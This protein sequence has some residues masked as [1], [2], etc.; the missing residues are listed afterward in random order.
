MS[1][2]SVAETSRVEQI[3]SLLAVHAARMVEAALLFCTAKTPF[4]GE[5]RVA[6]ALKEGNPRAHDSF[7]HYLALQTAEYLRKLDENMEGVYSYSYGDAEEEGLDRKV[8]PTA[9]LT[10][11]LRVNRKTAGLRAAVAALDGALLEEYVRLVAPIGDRM[12]S[13]LDAQMVD[14]DEAEQRTGLAV[15][16]KSAPCPTYSGVAWLVEAPS[17]RGFMLEPMRCGHPPIAWVP[18]I[19]G[20][21]STAGSICS[22]PRS[23]RRACPSFFSACSAAGAAES[24]ME[25]TLRASSN[26]S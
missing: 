24:P 11:I 15:V 5:S 6:Q 4:R 21:G 19:H 25:P 16:L 1:T 14:N 10:L 20:V 22:W 26:R 9:P 23:G 2:S 7:R 12:T 3:E 17:L 13:F 8:S 18:P